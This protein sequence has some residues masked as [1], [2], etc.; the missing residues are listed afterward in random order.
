[1]I[2]LAL[3]S[4]VECSRIMVMQAYDAIR[5]LFPMRPSSFAHWEKMFKRSSAVH[6]FSK[7]TAGLRVVDDPRYNAYAL[8]GPHYCP[9]SYYS[10][11]SF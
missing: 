3:A 11:K 1:M 5:N 7:R 2:S 10:V 8:L 6:F 9:V 4:T